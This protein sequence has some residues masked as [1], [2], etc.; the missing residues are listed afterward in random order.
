MVWALG[1]C[2]GRALIVNLAYLDELGLV[3]AEL[4]EYGSAVL[5]V[6]SA[7]ITAKGLNFLQDDGG[8][9]AVLGVMTVRLH[10]E[11]IRDLLLAK[12]QQSDAPASVKA[13]LADAIRSLP[14]EGLKATTMSLLEAGLDNL[15][16]PVP[17]LQRLLNLR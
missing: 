8:L 3:Q 1:N 4:V 14:A 17:L 11:T 16:N 10:D 15:P 5:T 9:S 12:V 6:N 2:G 13:R 7:K